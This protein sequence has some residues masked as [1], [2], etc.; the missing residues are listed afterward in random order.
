[1]A[2]QTW[3]SVADFAERVGVDKMVIYRLLADKVIEA[4]NCGTPK[5]AKL[6]INISQEARMAKRLAV[7]A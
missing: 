6:R 7:A 1:M 4:I 3:F 5:R 2:D